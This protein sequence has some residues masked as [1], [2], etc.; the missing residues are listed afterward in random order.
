MFPYQ[1]QPATPAFGHNAAIAF[2]FSPGPEAPQWHDPVF[3]PRVQK[4]VLTVQM[5]EDE[6]RPDLGSP[7]KRARV[8]TIGIPSNPWPNSLN[9]L[10]SLSAESL[11]P[12]NGERAP[13][14]QMD[15]T[16]TWTEEEPHSPLKEFIDTERQF[17]SDLEVLADGMSIAV[18]RSEWMSNV[19]PREDI[20]EML[21]VHRRLASGLQGVGV[22]GLIA[23]FEATVS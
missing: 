10:V 17:I 12:I 22:E 5:D 3:T 15:S 23:C 7:S 4:T 8:Q 16:M 19:D 1:H 21:R 2:N 13:L 14:Y 18:P 11:D 6:D 9:T 20:G